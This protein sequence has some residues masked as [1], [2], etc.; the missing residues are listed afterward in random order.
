MDESFAGQ[1]R[2][3]ATRKPPPPPQKMVDDIYDDR[4]LTE[5]NH[6]LSSIQEQ[7]NYW[8]LSALI[9]I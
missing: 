7:T 4:I 5:P 3:N 9:K 8:A 1:P 6:I 2:Q